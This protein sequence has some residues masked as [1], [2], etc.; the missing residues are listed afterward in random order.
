MMALRIVSRPGKKALLLFLVIL[1]ATVLKAQTDISIGTGTAGNTATSYPNP[2]QDRFEGSRMQFLYRASELI[3]AGM[4]PG[5]ISAIKYTVIAP[6]GTVGVVEQYTLKMGGTAVGTL[7][8]TSWETV[9]QVFGPINYQPV[10]G[11]N[12]FLFTTPFFWNGTDNIVVE[13]CNGDPNSTAGTT[14]TNNPI[15]PWTTGLSFNGSHTYRADNL[16]NLCGTAT[17][18][19]NATPTTRPNITFT[20]TS[21]TACG[22]TPAGGIAATSAAVACS[23]I[24]FTLSVSGTPATSGL[25]FQWQSSADNSAWSDITGATTSNYVRT[26][27]ATTYYRVKVTC[28]NGGGFDFST[29]VQV[30]T[31]SSPSG[32]YTINSAL[33]TGG[34]NFQSF[35]DAYTFIKCGIGG[36]VVF[37]V[38]SGSGPY[39]EQLIMNAVPN[40]SA[41]NT[42]TFN[43]NGATLSY[44][45]TN[46]NERAVIKLDGADHITFDSLVITA[47]GTT[48]SEYGFGVQLIND[49]DSNTIRKCTININTATT[50]TNYAGIVVS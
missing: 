22:G 47:P 4:G 45:S 24:P 26:Q 16:D 18:T 10:V 25:Q 49:A 34:S 5:T 40:A 17:T 32:A 28:S 8:P 43:G 35:N 48:T 38:A 23:G 33:P 9:N 41:T 21:A 2:L 30:T 46:T 44:L 14:W 12:T 36:P 27:T 20:W 1:F 29:S 31:P 6:L 3:A 42:V 13:V 50:S 15:V 37:N 7:S 19:E 11:T 39:N